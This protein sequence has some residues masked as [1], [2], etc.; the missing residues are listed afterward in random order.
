MIT[1][2]CGFE[3]IQNQA[4]SEHSISYYLIA[5]LYVIFDLEVALILPALV[6]LTVLGTVG[7][8]LMIAIMSLLCLA[9]VYEF[10]LGTFNHVNP[11]Q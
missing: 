4:R 7:T 9:F 5:L 8:V 10:K 1:Y 6:S 2:E 11:L 3:A